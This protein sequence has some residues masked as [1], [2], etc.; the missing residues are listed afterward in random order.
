MVTVEV[1]WEPRMK[2]A[3]VI[4]V[5]GIGDGIAGLSANRTEDTQ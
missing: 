2:L 5:T 3:A 4:G 1:A